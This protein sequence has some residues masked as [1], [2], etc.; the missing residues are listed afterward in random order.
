MSA[1]SCTPSQFSAIL[2][3]LTRYAV[4]ISPA[5]GE[6]SAADVIARLGIDADIALL[7]RTTKN[8]IRDSI[9]NAKRRE[10]HESSYARLRGAVHHD[11]TDADAINPLDY[12]SLI[13]DVQTREIIELSIH[14]FSQADIAAHLGIS[15]PTVFRRFQAGIEAIREKLGIAE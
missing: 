12:L 8:R 7:K 13:Q 1:T 9:R 2:S 15:Q 4:R 6:Q 14:G 5:Y 10:L 11:T 3:H